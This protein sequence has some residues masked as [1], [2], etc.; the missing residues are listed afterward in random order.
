M[1]IL[2]TLKKTVGLAEDV[3][4]IVIAPVEI[5][6]DLTRAAIKPLKETTEEILNENKE[7]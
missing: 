6:V 7:D 1:G 3:A 4:D 2:S 5:T